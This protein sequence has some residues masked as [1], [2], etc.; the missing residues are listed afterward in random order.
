M[1]KLFPTIHEQ[2]P[3]YIVNTQ[4][5]VVLRNEGQIPTGYHPGHILTHLLAG[6]QNIQ[7][8]KIKKKLKNQPKNRQ[9][10]AGSFMKIIDSLKFLQKLKSMNPF[11]L[12]FFS[13]PEPKMVVPKFKEP[14]NTRKYTSIQASIG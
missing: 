12:T 5:L 7:I 6:S 4:C 1:K 8:K 13:E 9:F 3:R 14:P 2:G 11:I 10:F